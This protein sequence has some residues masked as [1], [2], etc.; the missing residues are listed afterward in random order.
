MAKVSLDDA[1]GAQVVNEFMDSVTAIKKTIANIE[2][3]IESAKPGWQGDAN[4]ACGKAALEWSDEGVRLNARL[5]DMTDKIFTG[6]E[7][8]TQVDADNVDQFTNLV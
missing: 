7:S 8:K 5:N 2:T 6:N 3:D 1:A 4:T